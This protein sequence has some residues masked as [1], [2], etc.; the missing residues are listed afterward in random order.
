MYKQLSYLPLEDL[1]RSYTDEGLINEVKQ[2]VLNV[3]S[4][5]EDGT[6]RIRPLTTS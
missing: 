5:L 2:Q 6:R 1:K 3:S 4:P